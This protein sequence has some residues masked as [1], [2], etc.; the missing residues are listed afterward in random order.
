MALIISLVIN[1]GVLAFFKY[2]NFFVGNVNA[3]FGLSLPQTGIAMPIGISFFTFQTL[4]YAID[5]YRGEVRTQRSFLDFL[6]FVSLFPQLI[7]GPILRYS[8]IAA[9]LRDRSSTMEDTAYGITRFICGL[10]KKVLLANYCCTVADKLLAAQS[11]GSLSVVGAWLGVVMYAFQIYFDF[12]GYSDMAIGLGRIFGFKYSENFNHPYIARNI[13]DFWRRWH[14]SL[15]SWFRDYVYIPLGGNR[16]GRARQL[17][18][19]LVVWTLTG[20]W[21]GASWNFVIWGLWF[22]LLLMVEKLMGRRALQRIP[23]IIGIPVTFVLVCVGWIFFYFT[24]LSNATVTLQTFFGLGGREFIDD[25]A[26]LAL[27]NSLPLLLVCIVGSTP[28]FAA[29]GQAIEYN[30]HN[31]RISAATYGLPSLVY[32]TV[33]LALCVVS[34]V[35]STTN[36]FIYFRF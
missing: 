12:S 18:N 34:L 26:R 8:E 5:I 14:I 1:L 35:C 15:S 23:R 24:D 7:A 21:H 31:R 30:A 17:F 4:S 22:F 28:L 32:N 27:F 36:P 13:T 10:A 2:I 9:Q 20:F 19:M 16:C 25:T 3:L 6:L 11:L 29:V 33:L